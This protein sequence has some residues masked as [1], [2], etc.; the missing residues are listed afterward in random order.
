MTVVKNWLDDPCL[1]CSRHMN[2]TNFLKVEFVLAIDN[3]DLIEES[4]YFE[5]LE[6][7]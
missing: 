5:K 4:I 1:N 2:L 3:Y 7:D 6:L